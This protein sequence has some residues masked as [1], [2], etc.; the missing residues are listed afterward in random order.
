MAATG[1]KW[2]AQIEHL[3][4]PSGKE[5][6]DKL[7]EE[8]E[9]KRNYVPNP[10]RWRDSRWTKRSK[11]DIPEWNYKVCDKP[12][13]HWNQKDPA[14]YNEKQYWSLDPLALRTEVN[15]RNINVVWQSSRKE[16]IQALLNLD[17]T[18]HERYVR[19]RQ[20]ETRKREARELEEAR[21]RK[22]F[23]LEE[24]RRRQARELEETRKREEMAH[25]REEARKREKA[26][27][28]TAASTKG[29]EHQPTVKPL[30]RDQQAPSRVTKRS[31]VAVTE[32][33][34]PTQAPRRE[35][36]RLT[37]KTTTAKFV[38]LKSDGA[39][40]V[41]KKSASD[42]A[43]PGYLVPTQASLAKSATTGMTSIT[44]KTT[45]SK[46]NTKGTADIQPRKASET[47]VES[48]K[49]VKLANV[50][51]IPQSSTDPDSGYGG[52]PP[53]NEATEPKRISR[54]ANKKGPQISQGTASNVIHV[55]PE[56]TKTT[57]G[58]RKRSQLV[59]ECDD[60]EPK[61]RKTRKTVESR[62]V[63]KA[64]SVFK[65]NARKR[66]SDEDNADV[67]PTTHKRQRRA[68][69]PEGKEDVDD[70]LASESEEEVYRAPKRK[71]N[72]AAY[73]KLIIG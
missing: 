58:K 73:K 2:K 25:E 16:G 56:A 53:G 11:G 50:E 44:F 15:S 43:I 66:K 62:G 26:R 63:K 13:S 57:R 48:D 23:G 42:K 32:R 59:E 22:A 3:R 39:P 65:P 4:R 20:E 71:I 18:E 21:R 7:I 40:K 69:T 49:D 55:L 12:P 64:P 72:R 33:R 67:E 5:L 35:V 9:A 19:K 46:P 36:K 60:D 68:R 31:K 47:P 41:L 30:Q 27:V 34:E 38:K 61:A 17:K 51:N 28:R 52:S 8:A 6:A 24:S 37:A 45:T 1:D 29:K 10:G 70:F 14:L 54:R